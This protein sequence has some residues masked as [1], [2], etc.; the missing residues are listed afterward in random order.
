M[1]LY[2]TGGMAWERAHRT[3]VENSPFD[4]TI[5]ETARDHFGWAAGAGAEIMLGSSNWIG[6]LEYLHYDF[7]QVESA[8]TFTSTV[9]GQSEAEKGGRQTIDVVRAGV[10]YKF[11]P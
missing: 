1:L 8:F 3:S 9:P 2:G 10:S 6:R 11:T 4:N 7:G 5:D